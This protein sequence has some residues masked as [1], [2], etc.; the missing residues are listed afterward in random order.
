L[1]P[2]TSTHVATSADHSQVRHAQAAGEVTEQS[3]VVWHGS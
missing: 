3:G 2:S 1:K